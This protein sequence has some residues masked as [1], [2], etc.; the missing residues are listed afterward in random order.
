MT[1]MEMNVNENN[2]KVIDNEVVY[3]HYCWNVFR[4]VYANEKNI[5][6]LNRYDNQFFGI[7]QN[8]YWDS[9]LLHISRLTDKEF[10][11]SN[12]NLSLKTIYNDIENELT[13]SKRNELCS[14]LNKINGLVKKARYHRS[15]RLAHKDL[16]SVFNDDNFK[17]N[18]ISRNDI[19]AILTLIREFM[20]IIL[21]HNN[22]P[23][24]FY[25]IFLK[26]IGG[27]VL[28]YNLENISE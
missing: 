8:I 16:K 13:N 1:K 25:N 11:R 10:N 14:K 15:K 18:G 2:F 12:R 24:K 7:V 22:K 5:D 20:N 21:L 3:L 26:P 28:I 4:N 27:E 23:E 9:I 17:S 6:L 19:E